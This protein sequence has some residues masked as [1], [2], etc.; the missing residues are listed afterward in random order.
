VFTTEAFRSCVAQPFAAPPGAVA[1]GLVTACGDSD[2]AGVD[3]AADVAD[4]GAEDAAADEDEETD[5]VGEAE[6]VDPPDEHPAAAATT[7]PAASAPA[8]LTPSEAELAITISLQ[9]GNRRLGRLGR[10][11]TTIPRSP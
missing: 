11:P 2:A 10:T 9:A 6:D 3:E 5:V 7:T 1:V 8:T 4:G